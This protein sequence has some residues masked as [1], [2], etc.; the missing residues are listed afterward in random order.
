MFQAALRENKP[1][2]TVITDLGMPDI[3]GHRVA[4]SIKAD[5]PNTPVVMLTGWGAKMQADGETVPEVD[6]LISKP[7]RILELNSL[8]LELAGR[9]AGSA[10]PMRASSTS[11]EIKSVI[12]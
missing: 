10:S 1:F 3:D 7:P 5:S 8:L 2:S 9:E 12:A 6:A 11:S 4:R